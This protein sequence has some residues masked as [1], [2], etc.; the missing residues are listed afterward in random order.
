MRARHALR[1]Q[2]T[3]SGAIGFRGVRTI[4]TS[5]I[6]VETRKACGKG[7]V[8]ANARQL[9]GDF[10]WVQHE[11]YTAGLNGIDGQIRIPGKSRVLSKC[12]ASAKLN[13]SYAEGSI[14]AAS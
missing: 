3:R 9:V 11:I 10:I 13:R 7:D 1:V 6:I 2:F 14:V 4:I 5:N 8:A 12:S